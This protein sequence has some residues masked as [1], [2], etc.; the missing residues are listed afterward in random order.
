MAYSNN[1]AST[2]SEVMDSLARNPS[3]GRHSMAIKSL[4]R[5]VVMRLHGVR[6]DGEVLLSPRQMLDV[7]QQLGLTY[8]FGSWREGYRRF[9][10]A[11]P[12]TA[13]EARRR[14]LWAEEFRASLLAALLV[15]NLDAVAKLATWPGSDI[16]SELE[17]PDFT[18]S[19]QAYY[20]VVGKFIDSGHIDAAD[21]DFVAAAS[22]RPKRVR[23]LAKMLLAISQND[24]GAF[25]EALVAS[26]REY[27]RAGFV[28]TR[29]DRW[30]SYDDSTLCV[31]ATDRG[32]ALE[33]LP[34]SER[35]F[36]MIRS[37]LM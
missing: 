27:S 12:M 13:S 25:Q 3:D 31:L 15:S 21:D 16:P 9:P 1:L 37:D 35:R 2:S 8:F 17:K 7:I 30:V 11:A 34:A 22:G 5:L 26:L 29:S 23:C 6:E 14:L 20:R 24:G 10:H 28:S 33:Q 4:M 36:L 18:E 32:I 19:H